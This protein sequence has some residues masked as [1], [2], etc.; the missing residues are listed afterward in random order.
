MSTRWGAPPALAAASW[1]CSKDSGDGGPDLFQHT[2]VDFLHRLSCPSA[3][4]R[5][6]SIAIPPP[7]PHFGAPPLPKSTLAA[8]SQRCSEDNGDGGPNLCQHTSVDFLRRLSCPGAQ[9]H[10]RSTTAPPPLPHFNAPPLHH[11]Q[12]MHQFW[13]ETQFHPLFPFS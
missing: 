5:C 6:C 12:F 1:H 11:I 13:L 10:C 3:Q 2:S 4:I 7:L 8:A 9:I